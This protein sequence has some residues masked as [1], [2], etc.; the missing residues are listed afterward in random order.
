MEF[1]D[2]AA[3]DLGEL[4]SRPIYGNIKRLRRGLLRVI[5]RWS[6][7]QYDVEVVIEHGQPV[8]KKITFKSARQA[9]RTSTSL[10]QFGQSPHLPRWHRRCENAIWVDFVSGTPCQHIHDAMMPA[11]ADCMAHIALR[12]SR[13]VDYHA[14]NYAER[15]T[16]NLRYISEFNLAEQ[17]RITQL[18]EKSRQ[19]AP[20]QLRIGFDY[21]DP[22][23]PNMLQRRDT[24]LICAI[25]VKNLHADTLVGEGLAKAT[26]R[27]LTPA[28]RDQILQRLAD[29]GLSDIADNFAFITLFE[30]VARIRRKIE[31]DLKVHG[32]L[33][34]H[35]RLAHQLADL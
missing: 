9:Q 13:L 25:D 7:D 35:R 34:Q 20:R 11:I 24:G 28:R 33:R 3:R 27:W 30:R 29:D 2:T 12:D 4:Q 26:D 21:G 22:I 14:T 31:R 15:H 5:G 16:A 8:Y 10:S 23:A 32:R 19:L 6:R 18:N 17:G 1:H